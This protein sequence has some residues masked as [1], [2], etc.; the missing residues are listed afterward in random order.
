[1]KKEEFKNYNIICT[2][3][4]EVQECMSIL[5][6]LGFRVARP[7]IYK[8]CS[9]IV[10]YYGEAGGFFGRSVSCY[11]NYENISFYNF[12]K[13]AKKILKKEE[14]EKLEDFEVASD[15]R[16]TKINNWESE[17]IV[18]YII[19]SDFN[20]KDY[21]IKNLNKK[22]GEIAIKLGLVYATEEARDK[23]Q[24]KLEIETKLKNIAERLNNGEKIDCDN[25]NQRKHYIYYYYYF[26]ETLT[27]DWCINM[28]H[29]ETVYCL[30]NKFLYEAIKEIGEENL[31]KY[32]KEC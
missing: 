27:Y 7:M 17:K 14:K 5:E 3:E 21:M 2:N 29:P 6:K 12:K 8:Q 26:E 23:A 13:E 32:F 24:F 9:I 1:M 11:N 30:S 15:G 10:K 4:K 25:E 19:N 28:F 20:E 31:I 16:I 22:M 18:Y